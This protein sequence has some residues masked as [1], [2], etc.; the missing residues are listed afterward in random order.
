MNSLERRTL[1][2]Q[3]P[4]DPTCCRGCRGELPSGNEGRR[5]GPHERRRALAIKGY[6][7]ANDRPRPWSLRPH[8]PWAGAN[9]KG[10]ADVAGAG[11]DCRR[12]G[13]PSRQN[14]KASRTTRKAEA[15]RSGPRYVRG[16]RP[17]RSSEVAKG[18]RPALRPRPNCRGKDEKEVLYTQSIVEGPTREWS[19]H[20]PNGLK[21]YI[22]QVDGSPPGGGRSLRGGSANIAPACAGWSVLGGGD[23]A[24]SRTRRRYRPKAIAA[25]FVTYPCPPPAPSTLSTRYEGA[26]IPANYPIPV[27]RSEGRNRT[28]KGGRID[29]LGLSG[30]IEVPVHGLSLAGLFHYRS[31][32][33]RSVFRW[34]ARQPVK[35]EAD[36]H[37]GREC[38]LR[39]TCGCGARTSAVKRHSP[40]ASASAASRP[41]DRHGEPFKV[42]P[43]AGV[44]RRI[45]QKDEWR[46]TGC[47]SSSLC[48]TETFFSRSD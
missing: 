46:L 8:D 25:P 42:E 30:D 28:E 10:R 19:Q 11:D 24:S 7:F 3:L 45:G 13:R 38:T 1:D 22:F 14:Q 6:S 5:D 47:G 23:A 36:N 33:L 18:D 26:L 17:G 41:S 40:A 39:S 9:K 37:R 43:A 4:E 21:I 35:R 12:G 2:S 34:Q 15:T 31:R 27:C 16:V 44:N 29:G 20:G 32:L 48:A